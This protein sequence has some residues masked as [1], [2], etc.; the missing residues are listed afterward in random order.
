MKEGAIPFNGTS[1]G[2]LPK[3]TQPSNGITSVIHDTTKIDQL[4]ERIVGTE[5]QKGGNTFRRKLLGLIPSI[6]TDRFRAKKPPEETDAEWLQWVQT[7]IQ[8]PVVS[9]IQVLMGVLDDDDLNE[10]Y[11]L[12]ELSLLT[13][14]VV[15][16]VTTALVGSRKKG[17]IQT[18]RQAAEEI[19]SGRAAP[20]TNEIANII[21]SAF[22]EVSTDVEDL[23][24]QDQEQIIRI[25]KWQELQN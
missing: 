24:N 22:I 15:A 16:S 10:E 4:K 7:N 8:V 6:I 21:D 12:Q 2:G 23:P 5:I 17:N 1:V 19:M 11:V 20:N 13:N 25:E 14:E 18:N 3:G 9:R